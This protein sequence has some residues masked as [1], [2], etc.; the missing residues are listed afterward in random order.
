MTQDQKEVA[1]TQD[2]EIK[3]L[4]KTFKDADG[5]SIPKKIFLAIIAEA[6][7][8]GELPHKH[9]KEQ[10]KEFLISKGYKFT[11]RKKKSV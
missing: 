4:V 6:E 3:D 9:S 2:Y 8:T 11:P 5:K 1:Y 7:G 10:V